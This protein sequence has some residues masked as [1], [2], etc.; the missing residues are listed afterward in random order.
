MTDVQERI[1]E[2]AVYEL[3]RLGIDSYIGITLCGESFVN[4]VIT[5]E[6]DTQIDLRRL[7]NALYPIGLYNIQLAQVEGC[8]YTIELTFATY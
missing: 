5:L 3:R 8:K 4:A 6:A 1:K 2:D 7:L